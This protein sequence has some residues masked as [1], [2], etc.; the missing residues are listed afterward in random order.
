M[1]FLLVTP[2]EYYK[3]IN[4]IEIFKYKGEIMKF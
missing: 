1:L 4:Q 2:S 3:T